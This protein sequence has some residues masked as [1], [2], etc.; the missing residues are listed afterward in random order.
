MTNDNCVLVVEDEP[1]LRLDIS[2]SLMDAGFLVFEAGN[3]AEAISIL[4]EH[5]EIRLVFTDVDMPGGMDGIVLAAYIRDRWPP[6]KIIVT[7]GFR[8]VSDTDIPAESRFFSKPYD[9]G[10]IASTMR[11]MLAA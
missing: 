10:R 8:C 7:S 2:E 5:H 3:A 6:L 4:A 1:L 9:P 11:E